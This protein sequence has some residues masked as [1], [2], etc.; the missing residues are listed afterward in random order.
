MSGPTSL[1]SD[2]SD[3]PKTDAAA[4][5]ARQ[6]TGFQPETV[7]CVPADFARAQERTM[8]ELVSVLR[9][10]PCKGICKNTGWLTTQ[11]CPKCAAIEKATKP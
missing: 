8:A 1:P 6:A 3:T 5:W 4:F 10:Y 2:Q 7:P 11:L 9:P